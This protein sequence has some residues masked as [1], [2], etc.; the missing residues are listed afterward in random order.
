M[1][2]CSASLARKEIQ[3]KMTV[4]FHFTPIRMTIIKKTN[5][6]KCF[7]WMQDK[8]EHLYTEVRNAIATIV[9]EY[10]KNTRN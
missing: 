6:N 1:K 4:G 10:F 5:N 8:K 9:T 7:Q 3:I 2:E